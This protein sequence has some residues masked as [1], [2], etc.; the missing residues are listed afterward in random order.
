MRSGL[1]DI[2][3]I[4]LRRLCF[5]GIY[6]LLLLAQGLALRLHLFHLL[7][8]LLLRVL[9][10]I[11]LLLLLLDWVCEVAKVEAP[12][13]FEEADVVELVLYPLDGR[14]PEGR[15]VVSFEIAELL[16]ETRDLN[17][18][19]EDILGS[20]VVVHLEAL[21]RLVVL[22]HGVEALLLELLPIAAEVVLIVRVK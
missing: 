11:F 17:D 6:E 10:V 2:D 14:V 21:D 8:Y 16:Q 20:G 12:D 9:W 19:P 13:F 18:D 4:R 15:G 22:D 7:L 1:R 5:L 3:D